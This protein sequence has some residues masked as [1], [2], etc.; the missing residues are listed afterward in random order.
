ML[1]LLS[2]GPWGVWAP[3]GTDRR[4]LPGKLL[5]PKSPNIPQAKIEQ[6]P[7]PPPGLR[8]VA[9]LRDHRMQEASSGLT[10]PGTAA[11]PRTA[12]GGDEP[13][14]WALT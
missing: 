9:E 7:E 4:P 14:C 2:W 10:R 6:A 12:R 1:L 3:R 11:A 5:P 13:P 8:L